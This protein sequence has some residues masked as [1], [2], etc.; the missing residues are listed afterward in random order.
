[1]KK[2]VILLITL[3]LLGL[4]KAV[5]VSYVD[6]PVPNSLG[7]ST[8]PSKSIMISL[9]KDNNEKLYAV[10]GKTQMIKFDEPVKR[11]SITDPS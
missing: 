9:Y 4:T 10:V 11:I 6:T 1:M 7:K 3:F 5:A 2:N 8:I